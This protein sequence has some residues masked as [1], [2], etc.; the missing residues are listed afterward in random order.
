MHQH[1][2]QKRDANSQL[3]RMPVQC[4]E[5]PPGEGYVGMQPHKRAGD[6]L[7]QQGLRVEGAHGGNIHPHARVRF[8]GWK[9]PRVVPQLYE[10]KR[11]RDQLAGAG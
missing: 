11:E 5:E 6:L 8:P 10:I 3:P 9:A 1:V 4:E 7:H 2:A